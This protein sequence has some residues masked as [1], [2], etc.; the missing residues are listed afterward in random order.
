MK[1]ILLLMIFLSAGTLIYSQTAKEK[2]IPVTTKSTSALSLYN[3]AMKYFDDVKLKKALETLNKAIEEDSDFFMANYQ[4]AIFFYL[5]QD[6]DYF[7]EYADAALKCKTKLSDA[8]ELLKDV[9]GRLKNGRTNVIDSG[10]KLVEMYPNDPNSYNNLVSFQ[11]VAG[12]TT[13]MV[14]TLNTAIKIATNPAPFYNQ[15]GYAYLTLRQTDKAE[16]AFDRYIDL[17]PGNPNVYDSK[18]DYY[19][20]IRKYYYAYELYMR[21]NSMDKSFSGDKADMARYLYERTEG[22]KLEIISM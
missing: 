3:Q 7:E 2:R 16:E 18:G 1:K 13:G 19:M 12:D 22:K 4:L 5:N 21:A 17:E 11:S 14:V 6:P 20:F 15:L 10:E 9:L 8:E